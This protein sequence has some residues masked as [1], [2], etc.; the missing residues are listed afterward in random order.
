MSESD[1]HPDRNLGRLIFALKTPHREAATM[2]LQREN[3]HNKHPTHPTDSG[4]PNWS[5]VKETWISFAATFYL[6]YRRKN[7]PFCVTKKD[8]KHP[9]GLLY[10][11]LRIRHTL[12]ISLVK[13]QSSH[14]HMQES[15]GW[16]T[17]INTLSHTHT[18]T[19]THTHT[20]AP[21][22]TSTSQY[23]SPPWWS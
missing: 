12:V 3:Q 1:Y 11:L 16:S 15:T 4:E 9:A 14:L 2:L 20:K 23:G 19:H 13:V 22:N 21:P 7:T 8:K 10:L 17:F 5:S 6:I 18:R